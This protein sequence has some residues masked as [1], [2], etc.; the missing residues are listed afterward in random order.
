MTFAQEATEPR[1]Q[2][3][4][5]DLSTPEAAVTTFID[6][7]QSRDYAGAFLIFAPESQG[8]WQSAINL[9]AVERI[10]QVES[11]EQVMDAL[12]EIIGF[13]HT[14]TEQGVT[15]SPYLFDTIMLYAEQTNAFL[16]DLRG[17]VE[18][19]GTEDSTVLP[20]RNAED[21]SDDESP[22]PAVDV[23]VATDQGEIR[24][25]MVQVPSGRWRVYQVIVPGGDEEMLPWAVK[26]EE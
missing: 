15:N 12:G 6:L 3:E 1:T 21:T 4:S 20:R 10:I 5:F 17:E 2:Y 9:I 24:F 26:V 25:R 18:I 13:D 19:V 11:R 7:F 23:I 14:E 8:A 22:L 16:I